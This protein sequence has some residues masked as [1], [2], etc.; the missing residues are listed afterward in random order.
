[1]KNVLLAIITITGLVALP[2]CAEREEAGEAEDPAAGAEAGQPSAAP[3]EE[4][5]LVEQAE[6][7]LARVKVSDGEARV[8]AVM[9]VSGGRIVRAALEERDGRLVYA[10]DMVVEAKPGM[11][12]KVLVDA[13]TAEV[14]SVAE[15]KAGS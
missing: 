9:Q 4:A 7:L 15:E 13:L 10:Y 11:V 3:G 1:M 2:A 8:V 12:T 5:K 14:V 6:G